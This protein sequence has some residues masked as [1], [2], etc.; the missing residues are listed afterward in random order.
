MMVQSVHQSIVRIGQ[1]AVTGETGRLGAAEQY[2]EARVLAD[3]ETAPEGVVTQA[4][5]SQWH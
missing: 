5:D 2:L 1:V 4:I 3:L